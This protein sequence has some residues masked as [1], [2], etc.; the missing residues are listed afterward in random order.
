MTG[1]LHGSHLGNGQGYALHHGHVLLPPPEGRPRKLP[2]F[3]NF[4]IFLIAFTG[5]L[6]ALP[7]AGLC[8]AASARQRVS[9]CTTISIVKTVLCKF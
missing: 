6:I 5:S 8:V 7:F 4:P 2:S 1:K 9:A 3:V